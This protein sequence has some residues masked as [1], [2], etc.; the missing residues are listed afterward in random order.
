MAGLRIARTASAFA[1][2]S[3]GVITWGDPHFGGDVGQELDEELGK[4]RCDWMAVAVNQAVNNE[5]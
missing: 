2:C 1:L 3:G 4:V 5:Q